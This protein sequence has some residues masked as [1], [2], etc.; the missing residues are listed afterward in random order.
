MSQITHDNHFVPQLYLKQWGMD[1]SQIWAYRTLVSHQKVK[2]WTLRSIRGV[3]FHR[4]LYT[5]FLDGQ[6]VD[7]FERWMESEFE[8]P[9]QEAIN[10]VIQE[11]KLEQSDWSKL[12]WF[13]AAQDVRTPTS[14]LE[15]T[16]RWHATLPALLQETLE[17]SVK[18]LEGLKKENKTFE[19]NETANSLFNKSMKINVIRNPENVG[20]G[21]IEAKVTV[22]RTL[23]IE[24]QRFL[25]QKTAKALLQHKW[26]IA[27]PA[28]G[29]EWFTSD[30]PVVRLNYYKKGS[31]DLRGGWGKAKGNLIMPLSPNHLLF[32]QIGE[33]VPDYFV[34]P[35][36]KTIEIQKFIAERAFRWI[37][38]RNPLKIIEKHRPRVVD[39]ELYNSEEEILK[40]WH[41][42]QR[43]AEESDY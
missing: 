12:A 8:T 7:D 6:E 10:K 30:H 18:K 35:K 3:A 4:D 5:E 21:Y 33:Y 19:K 31:Y 37:F 17:D 34:F 26:G 41:E 13:L 40:H 27:K 23:W 20:G 29:F 38:A 11:K 25:L 16:E 14:Y 24:S 42:K 36:E 32:T 28:R 22:G 1:G 39:K 43:Q 9:A 2:K 15:S